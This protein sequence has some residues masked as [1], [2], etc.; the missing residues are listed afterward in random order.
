VMKQGMARQHGRIGAASAFCFELKSGKSAS[1]PPHRTRGAASHL[2]CRPSRG[3]AVEA[4]AQTV[5]VA[6]CQA[7]RLG[8]P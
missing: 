8:V 6:K 7:P 2:R 1:G 3:F 5:K 4:A